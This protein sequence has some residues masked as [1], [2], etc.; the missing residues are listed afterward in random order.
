MGLKLTSVTCLCLPSEKGKGVHYYA[1]LCFVFLR[2]ASLGRPLPQ[3]PEC[4]P[5]PA[6]RTTLGRVHHYI[7]LGHTDE[8]DGGVYPYVKGD[9][10]LSGT[11]D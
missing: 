1:G 9:M 3:I 5:Y 2:Q 4:L 10:F 7:P 8:E 11:L 6:M